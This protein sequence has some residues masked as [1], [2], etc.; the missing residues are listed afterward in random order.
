MKRPQKHLSRAY[1]STPERPLELPMQ[2]LPRDSLVGIGLT[3]RTLRFM[4]EVRLRGT[5]L[6][7]F[8]LAAF[9]LCGGQM[10]CLSF[11]RFL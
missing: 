5:L 2:T 9:C 11:Q 10:W 4:L 7:G 6:T 3:L 8:P 1:T